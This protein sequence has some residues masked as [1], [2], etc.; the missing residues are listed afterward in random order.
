[1]TCRHMPQAN[2]YT[3]WERLPCAWPDCGLLGDELHITVY[4]EA[5]NYGYYADVMI[6]AVRVVTYRRQQWI[7]VESG[8]R[9]YTWREVL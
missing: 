3:P 8:Y 6:P 7:D 1:M 2:P 5:K 4:P 9:A